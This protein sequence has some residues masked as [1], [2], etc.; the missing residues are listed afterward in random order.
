MP[1]RKVGY[2]E[3]CWYIFRYMAKDAGKRMK[4]CLQNPKGPVPGP[5]AQNSQKD[6]TAKSTGKQPNGSTT[7]IPDHL[8]STENTDG[9]GNG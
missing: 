5:D 1:Y 3:Q 4:K 7:N 9:P 8:T 2:L 6:G